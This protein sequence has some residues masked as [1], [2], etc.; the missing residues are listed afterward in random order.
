MTATKMKTKNR[1]LRARIGDLAI[2]KFDDEKF[3]AIVTG[4]GC[5]GENGRGREY[6]FIYWDHSGGKTEVLSDELPGHRL[7]RARPCG[8]LVWEGEL[9]ELTLDLVEPIYEGE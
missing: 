6:T 9:S 4:S 2:A 8:D 5:Y 7:V 1:A 3:V